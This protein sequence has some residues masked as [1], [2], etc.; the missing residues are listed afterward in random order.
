MAKKESEHSDEIFEMIE[1]ATGELDLLARAFEVIQAVCE[2]RD[3]ISDL[4]APCVESL[5]H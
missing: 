1:L 3:E 5:L 2:E 4:E